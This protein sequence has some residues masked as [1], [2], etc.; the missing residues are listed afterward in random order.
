M[1]GD[2]GRYRDG[3]EIT[4]YG[5]PFDAARL[6][7]KNDIP[8]IGL[9]HLRALAQEIGGF[10]ETF[11]QFEEIGLYPSLGADA[12]PPLAVRDRRLQAPQR[13][14]EHHRVTAVALRRRADG[15]PPPLRE[16][17]GTAVGVDRDGARGQP[18]G[19]LLCHARREAASR[20]D[21]GAPRAGRRAPRSSRLPPRRGR[22]PRAGSR[23]GPRGDRGG[24]GA[25]LAA[26]AAREAELRSGAADL[27]RRTSES[28]S[29][30][31]SLAVRNAHLAADVAKLQA[32]VDQ[33][34]DS[35]AW[36]LFTPW[37]KLKE[38]LKR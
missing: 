9:A 3:R 19:R 28:A 8:L 22:G 23:G 21:R 15:P 24:P 33:M 2:D 7:Y 20:A 29:R 30:E 17:R 27:E 14:V 35:L 26:A 6:L 16:A 32:T 13:R 25:A 37:W 36:R 34:T 10:D 18:R 4:V 11:D 1:L 12:V 31:Q 5:R 38:F